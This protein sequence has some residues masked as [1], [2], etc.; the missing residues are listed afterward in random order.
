MS[1]LYLLK[2]ATL[3]SSV[4]QRSAV[5]WSTACSI[6][7]LADYSGLV[8]HL[9][10]PIGAGSLMAQHA[11]II[12]TELQGMRIW[13]WRV[14]LRTRQFTIRRSVP[15]RDRGEAASQVILQHRKHCRHLAI[16]QGNSGCVLAVH[17]EIAVVRAHSEPD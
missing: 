14:A 1:I 9:K 11:G 15:L 12:C 2:R 17:T 13:S 10:S 16:A 6:Q 3:F 4:E 7:S 5:C 8:S